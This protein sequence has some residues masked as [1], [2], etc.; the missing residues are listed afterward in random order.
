MSKPVLYLFNG[1]VGTFGNCLIGKPVEPSFLFVQIMLNSY[2]QIKF[3]EISSPEW[4]EAKTSSNQN[5]SDSI[6]LVMNSYARQYTMFKYPLNTINITFPSVNAPGYIDVLYY[7][8]P[9]MSSISGYFAYEL[10]SLGPKQGDYS[11]TLTVPE[12]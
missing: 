4:L 7:I 5:M 9:S 8:A 1:K 6:D 11:I 2:S 3:K 10:K 12:H